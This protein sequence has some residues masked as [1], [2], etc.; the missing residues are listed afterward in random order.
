MRKQRV[1]T[2]NI[3]NK[4]NLYLRAIKPL[5]FGQTQMLESYTTGSHI[6]AIGSAGTGKTFLATFLVLRSL[7]N[8]EQEQ[9][10]FVRSTVSTRDMGFLPGSAQEKAA[11]YF[12][13][14]KDHV[15]FLADSGTAW[16]SLSKRGS[17]KTESTAFVR[18]STWNNSI[19]IIDESQNMTRQELYSV[20]TRIGKNSRVIVIGDSKQTDLLKG[21]SSEYL[22]HLGNKMHKDF[23]LVTFSHHDIVR[24]QF[25]KALIIADSEIL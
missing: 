20:L 17:I 6:I 21:S 1:P 13:I 12:E 18:G 3:K 10:I 14:Y 7:F 9:I 4:D 16:E 8:Q 11:P 25:C 2:T 23:D 5:T 19:V 15:N 22:V 24:S